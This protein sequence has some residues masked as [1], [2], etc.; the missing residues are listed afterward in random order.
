MTTF[1]V[2]D[3][4]RVNYATLSEACHNLFRKFH[5]KIGRIN[6]FTLPNHKVATL[7][8]DDSACMNVSVIYLEKMPV[9]S[10]GDRVRCTK[11]MK[12]P[13]GSWRD[14]GDQYTVIDK[15][16]EYYQWA[17]ERGD[18][19][20]LTKPITYVV[21]CTREKPM[22]GHRVN[23]KYTTLAD[24]IVHAYAAVDENGWDSATVHA[25]LTSS[26][27]LYGVFQRDNGIESIKASDCNVTRAEIVA[28]L[29]KKV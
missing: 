9:V 6:A 26:P 27:M 17:V 25:D 28:A 16:L 2:G 3:R 18:Y 21:R 5:G 14:P 15:M 23:E 19:E 4:V 1:K 20:I 7:D 12:F 11:H 8:F 13:D 29:Q 24:A 10:V 22:Y